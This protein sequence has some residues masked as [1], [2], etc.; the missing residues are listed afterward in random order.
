MLLFTAVLSP[1]GPK[2]HHV[3]VPLLLM[4]LTSPSELIEIS[5][6]SC[7]VPSISLLQT[8]EKTEYGQQSLPPFHNPFMFLPLSNSLNGNLISQEEAKAFESEE[9]I[10]CFWA[11]TSPFGQALCYRNCHVWT[12]VLQ[13]QC[14]WQCLLSLILLVSGKLPW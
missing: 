8:L 10:V 2:Q 5:P 9:R 1:F 7:S 14:S 11:R 6:L 3:L 13:R 4:A 12:A